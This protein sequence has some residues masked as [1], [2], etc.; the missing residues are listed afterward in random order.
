[1]TQRRDYFG[2]TVNMAARIA[3]YAQWGQMWASQGGVDQLPPDLREQ[4]TAAGTFNLKGIGEDVPLFVVAAGGDAASGPRESGGSWWGMEEFTNR[5]TTRA[6][7]A[8]VGGCL[9]VTSACVRG[10]AVAC[11]PVRRCCTSSEVTPFLPASAEYAAAD[12][13]AFTRAP[14]PQVMGEAAGEERLLD[15]PGTLRALGD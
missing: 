5:H 14:L 11:C 6:D 15:P 1:M 3:G 12:G 8:V 4:A 13:V 2:P 7:Y 9:E 10:T